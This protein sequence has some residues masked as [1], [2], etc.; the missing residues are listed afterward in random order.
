MA[1][2]TVEVELAKGGMSL[3]ETSKPEWVQNLWN[4][5]GTSAWQTRPG[6]GQVDQ[7][8]TTLLSHVT[9]SDFLYREHLG[10]KAIVTDFGHQQVISVFLM[11][12]STGSS[13]DQFPSNVTYPSGNPERFGNYYSVRIYDLET[14]KSWEEVLHRHTSEN[15]GETLSMDQWYGCYES[16]E[17]QDRQAYVAATSEPFFFEFFNGVLYFGN[18]RSGLL[19]YHPADFRNLRSKQVPALDR[20][21]WVTGYSES[22][23]V[24]PVVPVDGVLDAAFVYLNQTTFPRPRV[25]SHM[26]GHFVVADDRTVYFSDSGKSNQFAAPNFIEVPSKNVITAIAPINDNL[27]IFTSSETFLYQPNRG[28]GIV[29]GGRLSPVSKSIGC[30]SGSAVSAEGDVVYWVDA[31]GV[32]ST[33]NGLQLANISA[34]I[35]DFF[36]G[37]ITSPVSSYF[38][39]SGVTTIGNEQP[40][41]SYGI[42]GTE[43]ISIGYDKYTDSLLFSVDELNCVWYYRVGEWSMWPTESLVS[44]SGG[45]SKVGVTRNITNPFVVVGDNAIMLVSGLETQSVTDAVASQTLINRSYQL[46]RLGRGGGL[47]R[48]VEDEDSRVFADDNVIVSNNSGQ[49]DSRFYFRK[50]EVLANGNYRVL[51]EMVTQ[52]ANPKPTHFDLVIKFNNTLWKPLTVG[53][54]A[55]IDLEFPPERILSMDGYSLGAPSAGTSEAQVWNSSGPAP[56]ATGDQIRIR[57]DH[58]SS[59]LSELN[60]M[61]QYPNPLFYITFVPQSLTSSALGFGFSS[62]GLV[63]DYDVGATTNISADVIAHRTLRTPDRHKDDDVAQPV[64]W[65][66]KSVQVGIDEQRQVR[67]RGIYARLLSHGK[68]TNPL[69]SNWLWGLYNVV[70]GS[71]WKDWSTQVLDQTNGNIT[72]QTNKSSIRTRARDAASVLKDR[73][74]NNNLK[75]GSYLI[76]NEELDIIATSLSVKG[77]YLSHMAFGFVMNRAE[78]LLIDSMRAAVK[79][80]GGRRRTGR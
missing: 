2:T 19:S 27:I 3:T 32:Y 76:D 40:R 74:F 23:L 39:E 49:A 45:A 35:D 5:S 63:A 80:A 65:A 66:Y 60:L 26:M 34:P 68:A 1:A 79:T 51:V 61:A 15:D 33:S 14:N 46:L 73:T 36:G 25:A 24:H 72:F 58:A 16:N 64:D 41:T 6:F 50:P 11:R 22:S 4:P 20:H 21:Q 56:S 62:T 70:M 53:A 13:H 17:S 31:N 7:L 78:K 28:G 18:Q 52:P 38:Q 10:S 69:V 43:T 37:Q 44:V 29:S 47:D 57:W 8:D 42:D 54:T 77:K 59:S 48:S 71:D 9:S 12:A 55:V 75:Y 67:S 30:L